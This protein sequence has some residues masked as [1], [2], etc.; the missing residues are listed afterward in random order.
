ME[1]PS[2]SECIAAV[3]RDDGRESVCDGVRVDDKWQHHRVCEDGCSRKSVE[4]CMSFV[5]CPCFCLSLMVT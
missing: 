2:S 5:Q 4:A 3:G 1:L